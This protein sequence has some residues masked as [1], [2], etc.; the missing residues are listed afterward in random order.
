MPTGFKLSESGAA[1]KDSKANVENFILH[2]REKNER[3]DQLSEEKGAVDFNKREDVK[4]EWE[5]L[6][7]TLLGWG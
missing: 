7:D 4:W 2:S 3:K 6:A 1:A 5:D